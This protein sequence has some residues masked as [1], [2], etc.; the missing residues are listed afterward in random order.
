MKKYFNLINQIKSYHINGLT[1]RVMV[2]DIR[3]VWGRIDA[4]ITPLE[5]AGSIWVNVE[6][7]R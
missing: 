6:S 4:Q 2:T 5:G 3:Q 1:L 7:L